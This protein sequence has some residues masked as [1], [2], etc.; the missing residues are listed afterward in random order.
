[1]KINHVYAKIVFVLH[2]QA[3]SRHS[4]ITAIDMYMTRSTIYI[5]VLLGPVKLCNASKDARTPLHGDVK[6]SSNL[7]SNV[8]F[9]LLC[10]LGAH[11]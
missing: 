4:N 9:N 7:F 2:T 5:R 3:L 11:R 6:Q 8:C 1:M 10:G